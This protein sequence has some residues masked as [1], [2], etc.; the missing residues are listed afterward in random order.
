[1]YLTYPLGVCHLALCCI[2]PPRIC[3]SKETLHEPLREAL[4]AP[5]RRDGPG[6]VPRHGRPGSACRL[7]DALRRRGL[8]RLHVPGDGDDDDG[9]D[10]RLDALPRA[11]LA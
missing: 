5:L 6:D 8:G 1:M 10:G 4:P 3:L 2:P 7:G 11:W 9:A